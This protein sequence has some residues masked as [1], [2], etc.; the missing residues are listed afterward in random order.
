VTALAERTPFDELMDIAHDSGFCGCILCPRAG[1][2]WGRLHGD[3]EGFWIAAV[4]PGKSP[5]SVNRVECS[6]ESL[7][8]AARTLIW[9]ELIHDPAEAIV[10]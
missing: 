1:L 7:D 6:G 4:L 8:W 10:P 2:T 5:D 9:Q 3:K